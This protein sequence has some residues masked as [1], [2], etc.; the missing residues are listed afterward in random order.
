MLEFNIPPHIHP[1][2]DFRAQ[3]RLCGMLTL[4]GYGGWGTRWGQESHSPSQD[5]QK[6][7]TTPLGHL[8]WLAV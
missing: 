4:N 1:V 8:C 6:K 2:N 5:Q 7:P 3:G